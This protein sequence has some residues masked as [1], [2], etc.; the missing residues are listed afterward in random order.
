[1][2]GLLARVL[3]GSFCGVWLGL[4]IP[5][6]M[7]VAATWLARTLELRDPAFIDVFG[8]LGF[9]VAYMPSLLLNVV[10]IELPPSTVIHCGLSFIWWFA[11]GS[12]YGVG[13]NLLLFLRG[14][15]PSPA[16][17]ADGRT[18]PPT[19]VQL[20]PKCARCGEGAP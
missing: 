10:G 11:V 13:I 6:A 7:M 1:M 9:F 2:V 17:D 18:Q 15:G 14:N 20:S 12:V 16:P 3:I 5:M 19:D 8:Y 4:A